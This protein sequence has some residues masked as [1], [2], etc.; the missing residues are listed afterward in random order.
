MRW[1]LLLTALVVT[2]PAM[3]GALDTAASALSRYPAGQV[4]VEVHVI[5]AI[6]TLGEQGGAAERPLLANLARHERSEI[7]A[8]AV[9]ALNEL[10]SRM[11]EVQRQDFAATLPSW[12]DLASEVSAGGESSSEGHLC[13]VYALRVMGNKRLAAPT[14]GA[15]DVEHLLATGQP[16]RALAAAAGDQSTEAQL[17]SALALEEVGQVRAAVRA[18]AALAAS[19]DV[20]AGNELNGFGVDTERLLLGLLELEEASPL[21]RNEAQVLEVLVRS[22]EAL[23][24]EVLTERT[25]SATHSDRATAADA[26][27]RMLDENLRS[28]PLPTA[29]VQGVRRALRRVSSEGPLEIREIARAGL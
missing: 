4:P 15:G 29:G 20:A 27:V 25:Q 9:S 14:P 3:G 10:R 5:T 8:A 1:W 21:D 2:T 28:R 26:L 18:Y 13:A 16:H 23:T 11:R 17:Q 24:V 22:G 19:G 12:S 7:R 6:A